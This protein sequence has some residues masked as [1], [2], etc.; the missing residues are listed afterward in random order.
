MP[1]DS[2]TAVTIRCPDET[3]MLV[4]TW[5]DGTVDVDLRVQRDFGPRVWTPISILGGSFT[6]EHCGNR[7]YA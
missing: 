1:D 7:S 5:A 4:R 2:F 3:E 6:V